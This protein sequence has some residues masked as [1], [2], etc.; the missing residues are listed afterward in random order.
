MVARA[1]THYAA[2][3]CVGETL[4]VGREQSVAR[5]VF[6]VSLLLTVVLYALPEARVFAYPLL[7]LST[8]VHE[9]GHG[10]AALFAGGQFVAFELNSDGS[11]IAHLAV[12]ESRLV[13]AFVAAGG[14]V[15]PAFA[16]ALSFLFGRRPGP[17]RIF[18]AVLSAGLLVALVLVVRNV[19]GWIFVASFALALGLI[20]WKA[21]ARASQVT[22]VFLGTQLGLSVYSRGDYLFSA[23]ANTLEG[24]VPS[25]VASMADA[26]L[27]PYWFW[28]VVCGALSVMALVF[29]A[30]TIW[31]QSW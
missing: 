2:P 5:A 28:G 13:R 30:K 14:L 7:L 3:P 26:L 23:T 20:A 19:F 1:R 31:K 12:P 11:G 25:D 6:V 22:L 21:G 9:L 8:L 15:G 16:A 10:V 29:G 18:L 17:S 27:L 24:T 4:P